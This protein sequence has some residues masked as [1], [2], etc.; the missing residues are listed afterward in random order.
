MVTE[1]TFLEAEM[2]CFNFFWLFDRSLYKL[3]SLLVI[4]KL[5]F[6]RAMIL[7]RSSPLV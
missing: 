2:T 6:L 7:G 1:N 4:V 5:V 3:T